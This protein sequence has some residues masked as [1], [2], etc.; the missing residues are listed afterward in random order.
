MA[1]MAGLAVAA[2]VLVARV[3]ELVVAV[4]MAHHVLGSTMY[5]D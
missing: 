4:V 2:I 1:A 3:I 5:S